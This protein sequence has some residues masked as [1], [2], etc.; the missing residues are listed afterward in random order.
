MPY[1][2]YLLNCDPTE[3]PAIRAVLNNFL[4]IAFDVLEGAVSTYSDD[5]R[6]LR[7]VTEDGGKANAVERVLDLMKPNE[8]AFNCLVHFDAWRNN[9][10]FRYVTEL[11]FVTTWSREALGFF[12]FFLSIFPCALFDL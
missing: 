8:E 12:L 7:K 5:E 10:M 3:V 2:T 6:M 1:P 4:S 11:S 9:F